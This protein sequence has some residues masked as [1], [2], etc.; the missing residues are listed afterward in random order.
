MRARTDSPSPTPIDRLKGLLRELFQL[1][2]A[3]LDF[4]LYRIF[5]LRRTEV[6][7]F[8]NEQLEAEVDRAFASIAGG[9]RETLQ[10]RVEE[11]AT[12]AREA[13]SD[14]AILPSGEPN[15]EHASAKAVR[16]YAEARAKLRAVEASDAQRADVFNLLYAF[17]SRY[18][19]DGDF[20]ARRFFGARASYAVP[21]N[22]EEVFF[23]WANKDQ[24]YVKTG[25]SFRDYA[26]I[27]RPIGGEYRVRFHLVE[28]TTAKD[29]VKGDVRF[30][31]PLNDDIA[32]D[33]ASHLLT[34][35]FEYRLPTEGE[36]AKYGK[37]S[38][39]QEAV[40]EDA[41]PKILKAVPD[42]ML[43]AALAES[44]PTGK[45]AEGEPGPTLLRRRL[46]HFARK[47]TSDYFVH[48]NLGAFLRQEL[49]FFVRDQV[50]HEA[51]LEGDFDAKRRIIRVFR[52]LGDALINFLAQ[53]E[54]S[55]KKLFE[56]K[57]FVLRTDYLMP[58]Q[59]VSR[60]LWP[61]V[62]ANKAQ[63]DEWKALYAL[64]PK[65][66]LFNV[67]GKINEHVLEQHPTLVVDTRHFPADFALRLAAGVD[68][69]DEQ[70]DGTLIHGEN[71]QALRLLSRCYESLIDTVYIDPPYNTDGSPICY[72]NGYRSS[73]W[74]SLLQDR[75]LAGSNLLNYNCWIVFE[76]LSKNFR[77][78]K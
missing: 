5:H 63:L 59:Q 47:N 27:V 66:D 3:D 28:A 15:P 43:R 72:K 30:F 62:L 6:E 45:E 36:V 4:G 68:D 12:R 29:N 18:Y 17:F 42:A 20:I 24:Y 10:K 41:S 74:A 8:L 37:N 51:D 50:V 73:S 32:F 67:K 38:K 55:Q 57:K 60:T 61:E 58:I 78:K 40:L 33:K 1:D 54:E 77:R 2:T 11:L 21:Y 64:E 49:D 7:A 52:K 26:F 23:H 13:V 53:M 14:D 16:D 71:F 46:A 9:E 22:G 25:E 70:I 56:K 48:K 35:P 75:I 44:S 31:F 19:D 69:L 76:I 65:S 34:V 39:G